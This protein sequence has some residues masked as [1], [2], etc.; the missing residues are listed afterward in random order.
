MGRLVIGALFVLCGLS[1]ALLFKTEL[2]DP[3][4]TPLPN[5][6]FGEMY[7][8]V[9]FM[10][11]YVYVACALSACAGTAIVLRKRK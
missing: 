7:G 4:F 8:P 11:P 6:N 5:G 10:R 3:A 9:A 2:V 1:G